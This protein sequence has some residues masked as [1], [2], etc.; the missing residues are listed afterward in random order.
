MIGCFDPVTAEHARRLAEIAAAGRPLAAVVVD[1]PD[2]LL[3]RRARAELVAALAVVD[4]VLLPGE[5]GVERLIEQ[6]RAGVV[7][8]EEAADERRRLKLI[9]HVHERQN[10]G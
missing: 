4:Y 2:P 7:F 10:A 5:E 8:H 3:S 9:R 6:L 1:P